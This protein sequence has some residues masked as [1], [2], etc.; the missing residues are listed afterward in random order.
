[1]V[2]ARVG[3]QLFL[4]LKDGIW[5]TIIHQFNIL[6]F[7]IRFKTSH[8]NYSLRLIIRWNFAKR[9]PPMLLCQ[10]SVIFCREVREE[11]QEVPS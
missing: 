1:M 10:L 2:C 8:R 6:N 3:Q 5:T 7:I 11:K 4:A 9:H